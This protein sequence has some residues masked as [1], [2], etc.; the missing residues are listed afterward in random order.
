MLGFSLAILTGS[1]AALYENRKN[2]KIL[3]EVTPEPIPIKEEKRENIIVNVPYGTGRFANS[4]LPTATLIE[5]DS[6]TLKVTNHNCVP[7]DVKLFYT[8]DG[9]NS[10]NNFNNDWV[11]NKVTL[12]TDNW[13]GEFLDA[14]GNVWVADGSTLPF[15]FNRVVE[16]RVLYSLGAGTLVALTTQI[17]E[18]IDAFLLRF[19]NEILTT[20]G[21]TPDYNLGDMSPLGSQIYYDGNTCYF[22]FIQYNKKLGSASPQQV[23]IIGFS[24]AIPVTKDGNVFTFNLKFTEPTTWNVPVEVRDLSTL[25]SDGYIEFVNSLLDQS[26]YLENIRKYSNNSE[27]VAEPISFKSYDLDGNEQRLTQTQVLNPY[28]PQPVLEDYADIVIDGQTFAELTMLA[29]EYIEL[30]LIYDKIGILTYEEIQRLDKAQGK[31]IER[32][33][34]KEL[35]EAYVNF[36][37]FKNSKKTET[38][39]LLFILGL[40]LYKK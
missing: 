39:L 19:T 7:I 28:Q 4:D 16:L 25:D 8:G 14:D 40:L 12:T 30:K 34:N 38:I 17:G 20:I 2:Q 29:G 24:S 27:Q 1:A 22:N 11:R 13:G 18:S 9:Q 21:G 6:L 23:Q 3:A 35:Q 32:K 26:L 31:Q 33:E 37:G 15:A 36:S 10:I 5:D